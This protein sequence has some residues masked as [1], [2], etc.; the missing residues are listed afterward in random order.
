MFDFLPD[1]CR[2]LRGNLI[3]VYWLLLIPYVVFSLCMEFFKIPETGS[4]AAKIIKRAVVSMLLLYSF[5]ECMNVIAMISDG[6]TDKIGGIVQLKDL[7]NKIGENYNKSE[8]SW[9]RMREAILYII[10]FLSYIVAYL[11]VFV[12]EVLIHLTWSIL[13]VV[14]P[15]MILMHVSEKTSFVTAN[16]YKGLIN[17]VTWKVFWS[18]LAILLLKMATA[19]ES[20]DFENFVTS[21]LMNL[22]IGFCMLFVPMATRSLISDGLSTAASTLAAIPAIAAF[23]ATKLYAKKFAKGG[24]GEVT[25]GFKGTRGLATG[26]YRGARTG[27]QK[28]KQFATAAHGKTSKAFQAVRNHNVEEVSHDRDTD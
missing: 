22:C 2:E 7:L 26:A 5:E 10:S 1:V 23:G 6:I 14:S 27:F 16:L 11:G 24:L 8:V 3:E 19:P 12:A 4:G 15:L 20:A 17:V 21:I 25:S 28:G 9:L 13:Y 18:I